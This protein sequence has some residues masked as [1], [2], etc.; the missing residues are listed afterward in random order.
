M[1][2]IPCNPS[3]ECKYYEVGCKEDV[4]HYYWPRSAYP[5]SIESTFRNLEENKRL[6][7][8]RLHEQRH[9]TEAPPIKPSHEVM[10]HAIEEADIYLSATKRRKI[11]GR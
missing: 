4:D 6:I 9:A 8:R 11:Y 2:R 7:C 10:L 5:T 3:P 1:E